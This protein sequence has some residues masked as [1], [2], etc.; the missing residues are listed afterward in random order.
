MISQM[1]NAIAVRPTAPVSHQKRHKRSATNA[2]EIKRNP[3]K[4]TKL[5]DILPLI[6]VWLQVRVLP[7]PPAFYGS[8]SHPAIINGKDSRK[9]DVVRGPNQNIENNPMQSSNGRWH[10]C[11]QSRENILTRRA[12][13]GHYSMIAQFEKRPWACPTTG[14]SARLQAKILTHN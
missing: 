6:T 3:A 4:S 12:N 14:S 13:Q 7:G 1:P 5:I 10:G 2:I 9:A 11:L 8:A